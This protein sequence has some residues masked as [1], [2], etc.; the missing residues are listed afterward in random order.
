MPVASLPAELYHPIFAELDWIEDLYACC[1]VSRLFQAE[2]EP[3]MYRSITL[4]S[5]KQIIKF[6]RRFV[7][8]LRAGP[9][10]IHLRLNTSISGGDYFA[11][12]TFNHLINRSFQQMV[13][14]K[15]LLIKLWTNGYSLTRSC[16]GLFENCTFSLRSLRVW[17]RVDDHFVRFLAT[18]PEL[19]VLLCEHELALTHIPPIPAL[20]LPDLTVLAT[21]NDV[22]LAMS[23]VK[24][25]PVAYLRMSHYYQS[26]PV[27]LR[28][29]ELASSSVPIRG[30]HLQG[31]EHDV[32]NVIAD[33]CP[34]LEFYAFLSG[35]TPVSR[36]VQASCARNLTLTSFFLHQKETVS[37]FLSRMKKLRVLEIDGRIRYE[38]SDL[39]DYHAMCPS[40]RCIRVGTSLTYWPNPIYDWDGERW[41][42]AEN[43]KYDP[44]TYWLAPPDP[45]YHLVCD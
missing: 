22:G 33:T 35:Y 1:T 30:L 20:A 5:I 17:L 10:V 21:Q 28:L 37:S 24:D 4:D 31:F 16:R 27:H 12:A 29:R 8:I 45:W 32:L 11:M 38:E 9:L 42:V 13:N 23:L 14:L 15:T 26:D 6:S 36:L 43:K 39:T 3:L 25:R 18:Q 41:I 19:S 7:K 34:E 44:S 40:L 2:V